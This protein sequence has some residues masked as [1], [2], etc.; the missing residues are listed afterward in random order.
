MEELI[1]TLPQELLDLN[2]KSKANITIN[3]LIEWKDFLQRRIYL[4]SQIDDNTLD[5]VTYLIS[6]YNNEDKDVPTDQRKPIKLF[7]N[8][9]GGGLYEGMNIVD[10]IKLSKT[11]V[12]TICQSRVYSSGGIIFIAGHKRFCYPSSS[13]LLHSGSMGT[14]GRTDSVFDNLDFSREYE[15]RVKKLF[16]ENTNINSDTYDHNYRREWFMDSETM[17]KYGIADEICTELIF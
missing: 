6:Y 17:I 13:F 14:F 2:D 7:V 12:W 1:I 8:S 4:N 11:P 15:K 9:D 16:L 5:L 3:Y 10:V